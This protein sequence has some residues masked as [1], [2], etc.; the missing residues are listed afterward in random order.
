MTGAFGW[1]DQLI[2]VRNA[3]LISNEG[4]SR[5]VGYKLF[6]GDY[7]VSKPICEDPSTLSEEFLCFVLSINLR[8]HVGVC[9]IGTDV[10]C[11]NNDG[12][13][14]KCD[15]RW[16]VKELCKDEG[17]KHVRVRGKKGLMEAS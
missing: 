8:M 3:R 16:L 2:S 10:S 4:K 9:D 17:L 13:S 5:I 11:D 15:V 6:E 14:C 1:V 7:V 12:S